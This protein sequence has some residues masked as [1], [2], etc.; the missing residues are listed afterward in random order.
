MTDDNPILCALYSDKNHELYIASGKSLKIWSMKMGTQSR[1]FEK[2]MP[3]E[4]TAIVL[5][6]NHRRI[7]VGGHQGHLK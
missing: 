2:I 1:L 5:D 6:E 3:S 4:I 7:Y